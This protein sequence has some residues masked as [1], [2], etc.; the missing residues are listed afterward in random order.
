MPWILQ[1]GRE[2]LGLLYLLSLGGSLRTS[3]EDVAFIRKRSRH[4]LS[5]AGFPFV[6]SD[7]FKSSPNVFGVVALVVRLRPYIVS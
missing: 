5:A 3:T 1:V 6:D 2:V 7:G 4:Y